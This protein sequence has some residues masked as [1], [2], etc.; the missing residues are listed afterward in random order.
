MWKHCF[1]GVFFV[2]VFAHAGFCELNVKDHE[3]P[4][5]SRTH[6]GTR[7][8]PLD[9]INKG[10]VAKLERVWTYRTG[11]FGE[12]RGHYFE[13][14]PLMIDD[15]VY[16]ITTLSRLAALDAVTGD[17]KW[18]FT[19]DPPL[20]VHETG[21]GGLASR[22]VAY[23]VWGDKQRI[24]HPVRDGRI[25]SIDVETGIPDN[26]FGTNGYINLRAGMPDG[27]G[28]LFLSSPPVIYGDL[29]IQGFGVNDS[30][31]KL[32]H[33]PL[34]AYNAHT[35]KLAWT[36][37]TVPQGDEPGVETWEGN[38]W[39]GRGG[40]NI[41]SMMS[42]DY[43]RGM[44]FLP[45]STPNQD[46]YGG[47]RPG[48]NLYTDSVVALDAKTGKHIWHYQT[49]YHDLWD[50]DLAALPVL[51]DLNIDGKK[52]PAVVMAGKTA[53]IHVLNRLTGEP[54]FPVEERPV[55][56]GGVPGEKPWATQPFPSKPPAISRQIMTEDDISHLDEATYDH[57]KYRWEKFDH[58]GIFTPPSEQGTIV[59]PGLHGGANWSGAAVDPNGMMYINSTELPWVLIM[60]ENPNPDAPF[61]YRL[62]E[63]FAFRDQNGYPA[64][65]PPWGELIKVNLNKGEFVWRKPLGEFDELTKKGIPITGQENF[66]GATVTAGGLVLIASTMDGRIRA[67][68]EKTGDVLWQDQMP[69]AG[70]AAPITYLGADGKQYVVICA[71]GGGKVGSK[72]GDYVIAYRLK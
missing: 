32:P 15:T 23:G 45:V 50:Y 36:F 2:V 22:G 40:A 42:I 68:D 5:H 69:C 21:A 29:I 26:T 38:S 64:V 44:L 39:Q 47:D 3:W 60:N 19:P 70:Y 12:G 27:G 4:L 16:V 59:F 49:V 72:I 30:S 52:V 54:L 25:Y 57:V 67:F 13:C 14:T 20:S 66:G 58:R 24:F 71:G 1:L 62:K 37:N 41:W 65:T 18:I 48:K 17:E 31:K 61:R 56:Q 7:F 46:F 34:K 35:G 28:Y 43:E 53:F 8:S 9:Q 10:N 6:E 51:A 33:T 55:P 63:A 11:D